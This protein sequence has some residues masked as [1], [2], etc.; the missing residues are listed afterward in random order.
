MEDEKKSCSQHECN[1][2]AI[3][4]CPHCERW[5]CKKHLEAKLVVSF[6]SIKYPQKD[7]ELGAI[8]ER[9]WRREDAHPCPA[10]S[11]EWWKERE[12][13]PSPIVEWLDRE[14]EHGIRAAPTT[15]FRKPR[16]RTKQHRVERL[17]RPRSTRRGSAKS[18]FFHKKYRSRLHKQDFITHLGILV[19]LSVI[20]TIVYSNIGELNK[21]VLLFIKLGSL[22]LLVLL[23]FILRYLYK[24]LVNLRYAVRGL[25]NGYKIILLIVLLLF[26]F[27]LYQNQK[28]YVPKLVE[29][30]NSVNY[31]Y[32]N[33]LS[34]NT[35]QI[36]EWFP[37]SKPISDKTKEIER[38]I[39]EKTNAERVSI[40]VSPLIWSEGLAGVARNHSLDM[41]KNDFFSHTNLKGEDPTARAIRYGINV[42]RELGGGWYSN[43][44]AENIGK[45]STGNVIG[46]GYVSSDSDSIASAQIKSWMSSSGHR[47]NILNLQYVYLGVGVAYDGSDYISTQ[48]FL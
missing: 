21:I 17:N 8:L 46:I 24:I 20:F 35:T 10:Y 25:N 11:Y 22:I 15:R 34:I 43:G 27:H 44:I 30:A 16:P 42:R 18:W 37:P 40:G 28:I 13:K 32:F 47:Q 1:D 29:K 7:R 4:K 31:S 48:D 19:G 38:L 2:T 23:F 33:P 26:I 36:S 5:F 9:E 45:M 14:R 3:G 6:E 12:E 41:A 39:F